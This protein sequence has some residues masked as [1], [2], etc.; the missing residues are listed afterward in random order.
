MT[1]STPRSLQ[2]RP[3]PPTRPTRVGL[4]RPRHL[5]VAFIAG[6]L[7]LGAALTPAGAANASDW[8]GFAN[9]ADGSCGS[10]YVVKQVPVYSDV[11]NGQAL[12]VGDLQIKW[13]N[14]CPGNYA[15]FA[16]AGGV[17]PSWIGISIQAQASPYNKAGADENNVRIA[18]TRVIQLANSS[19]QVCA[20]VDMYV[21]YGG[22]THAGKSVCA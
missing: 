1:T 7:A 19:N 13:S 12:Y 5:A 6:V 4:R 11:V 17:Y 18:Y 15:R 14:G 22:K 2:F 9:P 16:A 10:N 3:S 8:G 20:Y 21:P